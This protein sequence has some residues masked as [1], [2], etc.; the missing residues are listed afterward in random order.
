MTK[1]TPPAT[2]PRDRAAIETDLSTLGARRTALTNELAD[3]R[4]KLADVAVEAHQSGH[5]FLLKEIAKLSG[6][7]RQAVDAWLGKHS[8]ADARIHDRTQ[9]RVKATGSDKPM[10]SGGLRP[11]PRTAAAAKGSTAKGT[12]VRKTNA[13]TPA[14]P[15]AGKRRTSK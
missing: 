7:G 1:R 10:R 11:Q 12:S 14:K 2:A 9:L 3:V 13:K 6:A 15:V 8:Y 5:G 4:K